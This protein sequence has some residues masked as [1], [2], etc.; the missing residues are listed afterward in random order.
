MGEMYVSRHMKAKPRRKPII[1][2]RNEM[3]EM[4]V[5]RDGVEEGVGRGRERRF[6]RW[7]FGR[8]LGKN[9]TLSVMANF[10]R[11]I[12]STFYIRYSH[13]YVIMKVETGM[14]MVYYRQQSSSPCKNTSAIEERCLNKQ[15]SKR[16]N[17][18]NIERPNTIWVFVKFSNIELKVVLDN[19]PMLSTGP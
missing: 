11:S 5:A 9:H 13:A 16:F 10:R 6:I 4:Y 18:D 12:N 8:R 14:K 7:D 17:I 2:F 1:E 15:E 19:Q 3:V